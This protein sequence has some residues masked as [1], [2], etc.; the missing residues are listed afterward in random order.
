MPTHL[1]AFAILFP[2]ALVTAGCGDFD[3]SHFADGR[4]G[5][6]TP[7]SFIDKRYEQVDLIAA[8]QS[9]TEVQNNTPSNPGASGSQ[10]QVEAT[11]DTQASKELQAAYARFYS[12]YRADTNGPAR[13]NEI[14]D[15][16]F[17]ASDQRC[18]YYKAYLYHLQRS[19]RSLFGGLSTALGGLGAI[20][21]SA[22]TARA[23]SGSAGIASGV[24]AEIMEAQFASLTIQVLIDGIEKARKDAYEGARAQRFITDPA[25][26]VSRI[27]SLNEYTVEHAILDAVRY[28]GAC[29][30]T[31]GLRAAA[32]SIQTIRHPGPEMMQ[33]A[34]A[35][36]QRLRAQL[37]NEPIQDTWSLG[38]GG[39][40]SGVGASTA[41]S[42]ATS[43]I[44]ISPDAALGYRKTALERRLADYIER[45][46][47]FQTK[48][49][50]ETTKEIKDAATA[51]LNSLNA[52][53]TSMRDGTQGILDG[54]K[55]EADGTARNVGWFTTKIR[56]ASFAV[57]LLPSNASTPTQGVAIATLQLHYQEFLSE[58]GEKFDGL[59]KKVNDELKS[60]FDNLDKATR[61]L[62]QKNNNEVMTSLNNL[63]KAAANV[64]EASDAA[65]PPKKAADAGQP[66]AAVVRAE[67]PPP[68]LPPR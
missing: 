32:N 67:L 44:D 9:G 59:E 51:T 37:N 42:G 2:L 30:I 56:E 52:A 68:A 20:F 61:S 60:L 50:A 7:A 39:L 36:S 43:G 57:M 5:I 23:L 47:G 58:I 12:R 16:L 66:A 53:A 4:V 18:N 55:K 49:P 13:R 6:A 64:K 11:D 35:Q 3:R 62:G 24:G 26:K 34:V 38:I 15:E 8:L 54:I 28:H 41:G 63:A 31:E 19:Q 48:L 65:I 14:Q 21:T 40:G 45:Y 22:S 29:A 17:R 33:Y 10:N 25:T 27:A 46:K 1:R